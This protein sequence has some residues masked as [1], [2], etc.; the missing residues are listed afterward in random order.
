MVDQIKFTSILQKN[1]VEFITGVPDTLLNDFCLTIENKW[2]SHKHIIAANE[3]NAIAMAAGYHL[4]TN[5]IPLVYMQ[6]SGLGNALNPLISLTHETV[7]SIPMILLVGWRGDPSR[8]DHPQHTKQGELTTVLLDDL[9]IPYRIVEDDDKKAED[10][11]KWAISHAN[12]TRQPVALIAT[13]G[14]FEK[15]EK[16]G[17]PIDARY[18]LTREDAIN[19]ILDVLPKDTIYVAATGRTTREL[20]AVREIRDEEHNNDFLNV[21]AMGHTSSIAL[22]VALANKNKLVVCLEGDAS[23]IMHLG[24]FT[25]IGQA[26]PSNLL[27]IV[28]NNGVHES[29]GGQQSAGHQINLTEIAKNTG[30]VTADRFV[31]SK[32]ELENSIKELRNNDKLGF[33]DIHIKKGIRKNM[34]ALYIKHIDEKSEFMQNIINSNEL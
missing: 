1:G 34:P 14:V 19:V 23:A 7:Y 9:D 20:H 4:A 31:I 32:L 5:T 26:K 29:V 25:S 13:K 16:E 3:G 10:D 33:I 15:G 30:Y 12:Q 11:A 6:N 28:L 18:E 21:G 27:H 17:F 22:G 8:K 2:P 24:A